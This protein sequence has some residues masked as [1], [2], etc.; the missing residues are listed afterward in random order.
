MSDYYTASQVAQILGLEKRTII[1]RCVKRQFE[2]AFKTTPPEGSKENGIWLIPKRVIDQ[3]HTI[4]DVASLTRQVS[5]VEL[6]R[7]I[8]Q[9][10][11]KNVT[12]AIEPL[13]QKLN[14]QAVIIE[15]QQQ[16]ITE[17][18]GKLDANHDEIKSSLMN[19]A[20][21]VETRTER[22]SKKKKSWWPF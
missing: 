1:T 5:P 19:L 9:A 2:G 4:S 13:Q 21:L 10:I 16:K 17:L 15:R 12:A 3:P 7:S 18:E 11:A 8:G 22:L 14:E 6:E 20:D